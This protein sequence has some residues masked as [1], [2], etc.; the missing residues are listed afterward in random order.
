MAETISL[1]LKMFIKEHE[2]DIDA[3]DF[4]KIYS[5]AYTYFKDNAYIG[6]L[7]EV[8]KS[9]DINPEEYFLSAIH[10]AFAYQTTD[11]TEINI[12]KDV[13][14]IG[15]E[16]FYKSSLK[17]VTFE[18][19]SRLK[20]IA[21]YAFR[22]TLLEEVD[23]PQGVETLSSYAFGNCEHLKRIY[24]P[25]SVTSIADSAFFGSENVVIECHENSR[26]HKFAVNNVIEVKLI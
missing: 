22:D 14:R 24:I 26:A 25:D 10:Q 17:K 12:H 13:I 9:C 23:L 16:A 6:E 11:V 15:G 20:L 8:F 2:D 3:N 19:G 7:T 4:D 18:E 1:I 5:D 21:M